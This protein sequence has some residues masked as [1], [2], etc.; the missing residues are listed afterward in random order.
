MKNSKKGI[1]LIVLVITIIVIIILAAAV[2]LSIN[3]NNPIKNAKAATYSNDCS[4]V[5][6]ALALYI[7]NF[8]AKDYNHNGPFEVK[9]AEDTT[10]I[11]I[12]DDVST[13]VMATEEAKTTTYTTKVGWTDLGFDAKPAAIATAKFNP[14]TGQF[15]FTAVA[16]YDETK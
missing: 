12:G 15:T 14:Y 2:L 11:T 8:M 5:R 10:E 4:E 3:N 7:S 13:A 9:G 1:S 16:G 6:S